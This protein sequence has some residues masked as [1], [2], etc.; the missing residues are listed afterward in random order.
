MGSSGL[1]IRLVSR[2]AANA[3][4][5]WSFVLTAERGVLAQVP[6]HSTIGRRLCGS[7]ALWTK[8]GWHARETMEAAMGAYLA[9]AG[10]GCTGLG[11]GR[12]CGRGEAATAC[13]TH[14]GHAKPDDCRVW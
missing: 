14:P 13:S 4:P 11:S 2:A 12:P 6:A 7:E 1:N 10:T 9:H 5:S 3:P 8:G